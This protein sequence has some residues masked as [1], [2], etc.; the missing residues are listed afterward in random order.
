V[1]DGHHDRLQE[2]I[3]KSG[4]SEN[5]TI[6]ALHQAPIHERDV[7]LG[8]E[9]VSLKPGGVDVFG[10]LKAE[11]GVGEAGRLVHKA[12]DAVGVPVSAINYKATVS[13]QNYD[14]ETDDYGKFQTLFTAINADQLQGGCDYLGEAFLKGR[15]VI[16]QWFWELEELPERYQNSFELVDEIWA[17]TL[18]IKEAIEKK[19]PSAVN[20]VH[21]P[22]PLVIP[23][24]DH[25]ISR[26]KFGLG[27]G[28]VFL[29]TFDFMSVLKRKNAL[30]LIDAYCNA[31]SPNDGTLLVLKTINGE[32]RL[33]ELEKIRWR[34][35]D[36]QDIVIID[37]YFDVEESSAL[38]NVCDCYVS[39]HRS[40]GLGLTMA[41]AM[42]LGKPVIATAYSGNMDFMTNETLLLLLLFIFLNEVMTRITLP[43]KTNLAAA[44]PLLK[45]FT[46]FA[47][48]SSQLT[49]NLTKSILR[50]LTPHK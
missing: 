29:F 11:L 7:F 39:L 49:P 22:L 31:F 9:N 42:L 2:W 3:Y 38:M 28:F 4:V 1:R 16:G 6:R 10:Y 13:R 5:S 36:R 35:K 45:L 50:T 25:S 48:L 23:K 17:P 19:S 15:Y 44:S 26:E 32:R 40:E 21:I 34:A 12:L 33:P 37:Q 20:V 18:F 43:C 41:E 47:N 46:M 27:E 24:V 30:G 14:F 8:V